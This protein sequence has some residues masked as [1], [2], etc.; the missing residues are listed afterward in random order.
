MLRS[1]LLWDTASGYYK[2]PEATLQAWR[3]WWFH[4]GDRGREVLFRPAPRDAVSA[5]ATEPEVD[6]HEEAE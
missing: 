5:E 1:H 6:E 2:N 3:N 4:T